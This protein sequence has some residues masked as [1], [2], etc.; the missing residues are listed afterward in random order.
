MVVTYQTVFT[1]V[2]VEECVRACDQLGLGARLACS[3]IVCKFCVPCCLPHTGELLQTAPLT[4]VPEEDTEAG[5][6]VREE[7]NRL[8]ATR[9]VL[10]PAN[11][12]EMPG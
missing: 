8:R 12:F 6:Q 4:D 10:G 1:S 5:M 3:L 9:L 7:N 2:S 11:N